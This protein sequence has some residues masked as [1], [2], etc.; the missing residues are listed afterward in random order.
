[1]KAIAKRDM[2]YSEYPYTN[3]IQGNKYDYRY[4]EKEFITHVFDEKGV[5][6]H[7]CGKPEDLVA[8]NSFDFE[9]E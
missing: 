8:T 5:E 7:F 9:E 1:M 4:D 6:F 3:W 2:G